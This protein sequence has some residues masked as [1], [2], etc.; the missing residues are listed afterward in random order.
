MTGSAVTVLLTVA[1][2]ECG[3]YRAYTHEYRMANP[4]IVGKTFALGGQASR[5]G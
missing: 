5:L 3:N 2:I 1:V 4:M